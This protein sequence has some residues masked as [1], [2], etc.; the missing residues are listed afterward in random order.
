MKNGIMKDLLI[1]LL[2]ITMFFAGCAGRE[3]NPITAY[4]PGDEKRE[5]VSLQTEMAQ[6]D[7]EIATLLPKSDKTGYNTLMLVT[8]LFVIIPLFFMDL[9][10]GERVEL[11]ACRQR[12]NSLS[13][14]AAQRGCVLGGGS[15]LQACSI[16]GGGSNEGWHMQNGKLT[17]LDC[18]KKQGNSEK[19]TQKVSRV[20]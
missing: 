2:T 9:K 15:P 8:G 5:C 11:Q 1:V 19:T 17:C 20:L 14:M 13:L 12:H 4:K 18:V 10:N 7:T 6:L 3:G 16:C